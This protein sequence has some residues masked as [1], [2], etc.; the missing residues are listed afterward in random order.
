MTTET[1]VENGVLIVTRTYN[2]SRELVFEA[3]VNTSQVQ[4]W[5][6]CLE[7]TSV[8]SEIE[9]KV[10]GHYNHHMTIDKVGNV[11]TFATLTEYDPP[12]RLSYTTP[13]PGDDS[14]VMTVKVTFTE[15]L[16]GTCVRLEQA[17]IPNIRVDGNQD[18]REIIRSGWSAA[19]DKL[20]RLLG[21]GVKKN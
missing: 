20:A 13:L 16:N 4:Q 3:W 14:V 17:G 11:C 5:W 7:C 18:L 2:A 6:G 8:R 21:S 10:G 1:R 15:S 12:R 19:F 9:P